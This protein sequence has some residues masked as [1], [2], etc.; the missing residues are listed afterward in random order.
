MRD[1]SAIASRADDDSLPLPE[2]VA[3]LETRAIQAA[4][5]QHRGNRSQAAKSLGISRFALLR[6]LE[7][8]ELADDDK[9]S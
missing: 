5:D 1:H 4:L 9:E 3:A 2:R 7:K 6:K 8:Y